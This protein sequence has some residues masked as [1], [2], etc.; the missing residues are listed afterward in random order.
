MDKELIISRLQGLI[1]WGTNIRNDVIE[2]NGNADN[3]AKEWELDIAA[4]NSA[5][6]IIQ[7]KA[8]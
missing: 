5:I 8:Q 6:N 2:A 7:C 1:E 4:L 3:G